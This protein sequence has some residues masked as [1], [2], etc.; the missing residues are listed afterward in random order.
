MSSADNP[1]VLSAREV[2]VLGGCSRGLSN[3]EIGDQLAVTE[4]TVKGHLVHIYRKLNV[5]NRTGAVAKAR[6]LGLLEK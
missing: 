5:R 2:E 3:K 1:T 6:Q 4:G